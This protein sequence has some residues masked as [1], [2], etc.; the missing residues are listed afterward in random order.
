MAS[1]QPLR[2]AMPFGASARDAEDYYDFV[3]SDDDLSGDEREDAA[4]KIPVSALNEAVASA[5]DVSAMM[6]A[7]ALPLGSATTNRAIFTPFNTASAETKKQSKTDGSVP[8][9]MELVASGAVILTGS[10]GKQLK[11]SAESLAQ[12]A[13]RK[14]QLESALDAIVSSSSSGGGGSGAALLGG[15]GTMGEAPF[16]FHRQHDGAGTSD[17]IMTSASEDLAQNG[18]QDNGMVKAATASAKSNVHF[19]DDTN[20]SPDNDLD[21]LY[22]DNM[23]DADEKWV[24][25]NFREQGTGETDASLCCPCCFLTVCMDCQRHTTY[26]NQYRSVAAI[27]CRI[28]KDEILT[29]T[30]GTATALALPFQKRL[31][32]AATRT[33]A[34]GESFSLLSPDEFHPVACSDCGTTVG[35]YDRNQQYHFFNVLPSNC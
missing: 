34:R 31:N 23:D 7:D 26:L 21:P 32:I 29:Y 12:H 5:N 20:G 4:S 13:A 15:A 28:K 27:N 3:P 2:A 10:G 8:V 35:V 11:V 14:S 16:R 17:V 33:N 22:D 24:Q 19:P 30:S 9:P 25:Q 6:A 1:R 18:L